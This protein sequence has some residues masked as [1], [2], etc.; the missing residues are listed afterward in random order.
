VSPLPGVVHLDLI[1]P[2]PHSQGYC[3]AG[4][5]CKLKHQLPSPRGGKRPGGATA[6]GA[7]KQY[8]IELLCETP[9][10]LAC[11]ICGYRQEHDLVRKITWVCS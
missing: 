7:E 3:A 5:A 1:S 2:T 11:S 4:S 9:S 6:A 10:H 8:V